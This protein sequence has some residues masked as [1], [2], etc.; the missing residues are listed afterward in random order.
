VLL[1]SIDQ[2]SVC[3]QVTVEETKKDRRLSESTR[4]WWEP[5]PF[6]RG[7]RQDDVST[8]TTAA[9]EQIA[10]GRM[11]QAALPHDASSPLTGSAVATAEALVAPP[12]ATQQYDL[13]LMTRRQPI[14][15]DSL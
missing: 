3:L 14:G 7:G 10:L 8:K 11:N 4:L 9:T 1:D 2:H 6:Q 5:H 15:Q 12:T 13:G